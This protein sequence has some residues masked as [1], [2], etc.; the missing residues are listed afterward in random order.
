MAVWGRAR[1]C[2]ERGDRDVKVD[3]EIG[4]D[5]TNRDIVYD[6]MSKCHEGKTMSGE[7]VTASLHDASI[8]NYLLG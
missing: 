1:E 3:I 5:K 7:T 4:N 6:P 2:E 8:R